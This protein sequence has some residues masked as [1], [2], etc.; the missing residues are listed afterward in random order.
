MNKIR[1]FFFTFIIFL[2]S[3][4]IAHSQNFGGSFADGAP[5]SAYQIFTDSSMFNGTLGASDIT[6]Q[7]S[8]ETLS[9]NVSGGASSLSDLTDVNSA[10]ATSGNILVAD[11]TDWESV[12][13]VSQSIVTGPSSATNRAFAK[14]SG[15]TGKVIQNSTTTEDA[16]GRVSIVSGTNYPTLDL[17]ITSGATTSWVNY[18]FGSTTQMFD[19]ELFSTAGRW[20]ND[21]M[22]NVWAEASLGTYIQLIGSTN[23]ASITGTLVLPSYPSCT[24]KLITDINGVVSCSGSL[25]VSTLSDLND[26]NT[27]TATSGNI[28]MADGTDW[29]SVSVAFKDNGTE[30]NLNTSTDEVE[31]GSSGTHSAKFAI[32]GDSDEVQLLIQANSSQIADV[33]TIESSDGTDAIRIRPLTSGATASMVVMNQ[34]PVTGVTTEQSAINVNGTNTWT[35]A[36]GTT[37]TTQ[38]LA[39]FSAPTW[40]GVAGGGAETI[41]NGATLVVTDAPTAG[42]NLTITNPYAFWVDNGTSR[43]DGFINAGNGTFTVA[44]AG[45]DVGVNDDLEVNDDVLFNSD[46]QVDGNSNTSGT[47]TTNGDPPTFSGMSPCGTTPSAVASNTD[48]AGKFTVGTGIVTGCTLTFGDSHAIAPAC[49]CNDETNILLLQAVSTTTTLTC[50]AA[51][52]IAGDTISYQCQFNAT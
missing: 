31:I 34:F 37:L 13:T 28:L 27:A 17:S 50:S 18:L 21:A 32:D 2:L 25:N 48:E 15:T 47:N 51:T 7:Q 29:E 43:F 20:F 35:L 24:S 1:I 41:T 9:E 4:N 14:Y 49:T 42:A 6:V 38:R 44:T 40:D 33:V 30:V 22:T 45:G 3:F 39:R 36:D 10:T 5:N 46:L 52:T 12:T 26:V 19:G 8:L 11:G 16:S 23:Q